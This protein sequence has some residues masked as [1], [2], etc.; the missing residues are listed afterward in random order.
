M[1]TDKY[2][3]VILDEQDLCELFLQNPDRTVRRCLTDQHI[4]FDKFLELDKI[5]ELI[6]YQSD[7]QTESIE[8]YDRRLQSNWYMPEEYRQLDIAEW[9]LNQCQSDHERQRVGQELLMY[10]DRDLF[11]LL[12]FLKYLVD[13]AREHGIVLGVGRGSSVASY[14]L[15]LIGVHRIDS[16]YYSL[17]IN[18]FLR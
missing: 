11:P 9:T 8:Q 14:V 13:T 5:P 17:D 1:I 4:E 10:L 15:F 18:E 6:Q 16:L 2:G 12:Q 7:D 3:Q